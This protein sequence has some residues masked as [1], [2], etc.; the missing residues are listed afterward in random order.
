MKENF[1]GPPLVLSGEFLVWSTEQQYL[2]IMTTDELLSHSATWFL[3]M[4]ILHWFP[5]AAPEG[6]YDIPFSPVGRIVLEV[7]DLQ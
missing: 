1:W 7:E 2:L 6:F 3:N 5:L 4:G